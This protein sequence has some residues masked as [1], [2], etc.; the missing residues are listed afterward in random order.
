MSQ[1]FPRLRR[2][3]MDETV[4]PS[5]PAP[6]APRRVLRRL[7]PLVLL[8]GLGGV[9][10]AGS[11]LAYWSLEGRAFSYARAERERRRLVTPALPDQTETPE[12][13]PGKP[14]APLSCGD[15]HPF[16]GTSYNP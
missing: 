12:A 1:D 6:R 8:A 16:L 14:P 3:F 5:S 9:I 4:T 15:V 13:P 10:E 11:S 7:F 2:H